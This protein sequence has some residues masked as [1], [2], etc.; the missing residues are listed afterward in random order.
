MQLLIHWLIRSVH[1]HSVV[2]AE[3]VCFFLMDHSTRQLLSSL[4]RAE[5]AWVNAVI[6]IV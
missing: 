5:G 2:D 6:M 4:C 1:V 3:G